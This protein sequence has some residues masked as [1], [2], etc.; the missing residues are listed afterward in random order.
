MQT[1]G[2]ASDKL[3]WVLIGERPHNRDEVEATFGIAVAGV[4][5][6]D[7]RGAKAL[8]QGSTASRLRRTAIVRTAKALAGDLAQS[9]HPEIGETDAGEPSAVGELADLASLGGLTHDR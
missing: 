3:G 6:D 5:A 8:E 9:L 2:L 1:L 4:I 7:P